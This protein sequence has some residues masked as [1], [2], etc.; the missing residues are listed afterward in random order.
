MTGL[1]FLVFLLAAAPSDA[2]VLVAMNDDSTLVV[3]S[4]GRIRGF[5]IQGEELW[6]GSGPT[7]PLFG[8]VSADGARAAFLDPLANRVAIVTAN[9]TTLDVRVPESPVAAM[10][11]EGGLFVLSRDG[12][13]LSRIENDGAVRSV[14]TSLDPSHLFIEGTDVFVY[15]RTAG[16]IEK[17]DGRTLNRMATAE[18]TIG[19]SDFTGDGRDLWIASP[20]EGKLF[21]FS[22][23]TLI[24]RDPVSGGAVPVDIQVL[25]R[26]GRATASRLAVADPS[27]RRI[28]EVEGGES[29]AAAFGRGFLR[30]LLGLGL[31]RPRSSE[32]PGGVDRIFNA[33]GDFWAF[34][35]G[36][37]TLFQV[38]A[39]GRSRALARGLEWGKFAVTDDT[40]WVWDA[41]SLSRRTR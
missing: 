9:G 30:G 39:G 31:Y 23:E 28:W 1:F 25:R 5:S 40:V 15:G 8:V 19:G 11:G 17:F 10:F 24:V 32:F 26:E 41:G 35:S 14:P 29:E 12:A 18:A 36:S 2:D 16:R 38:R 21:P 13:A 22:Q 27:S 34:D 20:R 6:S 7:H 3:A 37:G 4:E 33:A